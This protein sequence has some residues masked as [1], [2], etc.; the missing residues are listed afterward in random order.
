MGNTFAK[1]DKKAAGTAQQNSS[2]GMETDY[3]FI[4]ENIDVL[5]ILLG[6]D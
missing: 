4:S 2:K 6:F 1:K 3:L 5:H